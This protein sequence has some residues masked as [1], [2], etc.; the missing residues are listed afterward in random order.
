M[1]PLSVPRP[2]QVRA[3]PMRLCTTA[4]P[5]AASFKERVDSRMLLSISVGPWETSTKMSSPMP[6]NSSLSGSSL[7]VGRVLWWNRFWV[8]RVPWACQ[9]SHKPLVQ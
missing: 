7:R 9:S 5:W 1:A 8:T 2:T 4:M 6:R 3:P